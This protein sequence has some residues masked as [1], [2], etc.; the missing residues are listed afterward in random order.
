VAARE[1]PDLTLFVGIVRTLEQIGAPY[2]IIG[3]FAAS[4]YGITRTTQD[5]DVVVDLSEEHIESLVAHYP[6]PRYHAD[7]DQMRDSIRLGIMFNIIDTEQ[8]E[9]ADLLPV[10]MHPDYRSVLSGRVRYQLRARGSEP[11]EAWFAR[12]E[13]VIIGK[14]HAWAEG[15]SR[16][17]ETDIYEMLVFR[18]LNLDPSQTLDEAAVDRAAVA[19]GP[20]VAQFWAAAKEAARREAERAREE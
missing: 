9:K 15:R 5:I 19:L 17:H 11:F 7:P 8:G 13:D 10:S 20:E 4:L 2:V 6:V 18:Y 3:A 1:D 16:K 14:L 12:P